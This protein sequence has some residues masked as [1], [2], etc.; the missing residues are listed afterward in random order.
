[1]CCRKAPTK[2]YSLKLEKKMLKKI[3]RIIFEGKFLMSTLPKPTV[4]AKHE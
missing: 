2:L 4:L 3:L 1:M